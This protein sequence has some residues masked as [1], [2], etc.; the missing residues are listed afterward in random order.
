MCGIAYAARWGDVR[1]TNVA[2]FIECCRE[3]LVVDSLGRLGDPALEDLVLEPW[4]GIS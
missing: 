4:T 2:L 1:T 3:D